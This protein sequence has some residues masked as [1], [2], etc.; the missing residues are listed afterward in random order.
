MIRTL[1]IG[2]VGAGVFAIAAERPAAP[3]AAEGGSAQFTL[4]DGTVIV[5]KTDLKNIEVVTAYGSL[6]VPMGDI[7]RIRVGKKAD[8]E[9]KAR[10][11]RCISDL[12]SKDFAARDAATTELSKLGRLAYTELRKAST[13]EDLEVKERASKLLDDLGSPEEDADV[14]P[15]DDEVVTPTFT[16]VGA[17]KLDVLTITT[18]F[19]PLKVAKKDLG[20]MSVGDGESVTRVIM[21]PAKSTAGKMLATGVRVRRGDRLTFSAQGNIAYR[22]YG[23]TQFTPEG[24]TNY[25]TWGD[26]FL[27]G[28]LIG[29]IGPGGQPFKIGERYSDKSDVEGELHLGV[30]A[31]DSAGAYGTGEYKVRLQVQP[32]AP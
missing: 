31:N 2:F 17:I 30:A 25:G 14:P 12:G 4:R 26:N 24:S 22:N 27:V 13:S 20:K 7:V 1:L 11:D 15:E 23:G 9:L 21:V 29:K 28:A 18:K 6:T 32:G 16:I 19:G 3:G 10:I 8:R 5:G